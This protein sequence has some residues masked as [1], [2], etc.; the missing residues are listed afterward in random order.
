V[1][2]S[3]DAYESGFVV[4]DVHNAPVANSDA[5]LILIAS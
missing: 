5:P 4:D 2:Y 1:G 3:G